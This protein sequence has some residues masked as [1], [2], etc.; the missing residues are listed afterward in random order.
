MLYLERSPIYIING[1]KIM[2]QVKKRDGA[3]V[4]YDMSKISIALSKTMQK[5]Q[6]IM[7]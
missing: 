2:F 5:K 7:L 1:G 3:I 4:D 6:I